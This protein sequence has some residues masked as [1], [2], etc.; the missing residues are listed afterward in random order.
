ME[1]LLPESVFNL[2][3]PGDTVILKP[4]WVMEGHKY[5]P[6]E[7][8][9]VIT[10]PAVITAVLRHV[11][12]RLC[13]SGRVVIIDGPT[14]EASFSKLI[15]HYP[16]S[17]WHEIAK[18][19]HVTLEVIDLREHEWETR[20]DIIVK[21]H[22]LPGDPRG[23]TEVNLRDASSEFWGHQKSNRGYHGADYDRSETN[24]AHDGHHNLYR[25]SRTVIEGDV[26]I[27]LPKLKTH[28][29]AGI[30][31]CLKNLVGINTYKN[32]LPHHSEG[33]PS[34][35]GDQFPVDNVNA[36][37]EGPLMAFLKRHVLRNP[38][39]ARLLSPFNTLGK[40]I[41]GDTRQVVRS[42][43]WYGNDTIWRMILDLN[44]VLFYA[45]PDGSLRE[46]TLVNAKRYIGIVDGILAGEGHGPLAPDPVEMGYLFCGTNPV[47]IDAVCA[48]FMGFDP[49]KIPSI[50]RAFQVSQY[51]LCDFNLDD[52]RVTV[53][54][55][56]FPLANLPAELIVPCEPQ[57]GWKGHI[58]R[59]DEAHAPQD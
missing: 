26:F 30:T 5:R 40:Q 53:G 8:E 59:Q 9:Y 36:R 56:E 4:N 28:R 24:R 1:A 19:S 16:V 6:D 10:H 43:N 44:K 54:E 22:E 14:T 3:K 52:V 27:N 51:P 58:E 47:A 42:G 48:S 39:L 11:L 37:I 38:L 15:A 57:F 7:W 32:Y 20:N 21:R 35:G 55:G 31:C 13:G 41:F 49:L 50:S 29:K 18:A 25:V 12:K 23:K 2:V 45:N 33:G 34:E 17:M 46:G